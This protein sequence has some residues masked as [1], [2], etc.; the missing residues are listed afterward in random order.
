MTNLTQI[1][2]L[3]KIGQDL[4][5]KLQTILNSKQKI[6]SG[7]LAESI[8]YEIIQG[9][10]GPVIQINALPYFSVVDQ[11]RR[12]SLRIQN[13]R[14]YGLPPEK[15]ILEWMKRKSIPERYAYGIRYNI[16]KFGI[17]G[18]YIV[19][20][21]LNSSMESIAEEIAESYAIFIAEDISKTINTIKP[22]TINL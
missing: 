1:A 19:D 10:N 8:S 21:I 17:K 20:P 18:L 9:D 16:A 15:P 3:D 5:K 7:D 12:P 4:V 22:V 11:G 13:N 2:N 14:A 6:A